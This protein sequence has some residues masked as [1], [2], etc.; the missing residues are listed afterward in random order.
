MREL[1]AE[2]T[3]NQSEI[4][5]LM[6]QF[7]ENLL[8]EFEAIRAQTQADID[9][10]T[11]QLELESIGIKDTEYDRKQDKAQE[12][13]NILNQ[14]GKELEE[15]LD[16]LNK[17]YADGYM[18]E[19]VYLEQSRTLADEMLSNEQERYEKEQELRQMVM[20]QWNYF[21]QQR[22]NAIKDE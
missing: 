14:R 2:V 16:K 10:L 15:A 21:N 5:D 17:I 20:D 12:E 13:L 3:S 9:D 6:Q 11:R 1:A 8:A 19:A 4:F 22:D 18:T 7:N